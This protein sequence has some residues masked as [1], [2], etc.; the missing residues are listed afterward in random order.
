VTANW[1]GFD[2]RDA[3]DEELEKDGVSAYLGND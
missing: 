1:F 2:E 3:E